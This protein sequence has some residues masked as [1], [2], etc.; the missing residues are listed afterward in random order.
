[1]GRGEDRGELEEKE[2]GGGGEGGEGGHGGEG[3]AGSSGGSGRSAAGCSSPG[4]K[5]L[6]LGMAGPRPGSPG[7]GAGGTAGPSPGVTC[8]AAG[9]S[10][11][12]LPLGPNS[13]SNTFIIEIF[14]YSIK[15]FFHFK[16]R[17]NFKKNSK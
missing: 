3:R 6:M 5:G 17:I 16:F 7:P 14:F 2:S 15:I 4:W 13:L 10:G 12:P 8:P 11:T 9:G 1:M